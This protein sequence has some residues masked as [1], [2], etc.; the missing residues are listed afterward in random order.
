MH[1]NSGFAGGCAASGLASLLSSAGHYT[2]GVGDG[3]VRVKRQDDKDLSI[4][5]RTRAFRK[6]KSRS[7]DSSLKWRGITQT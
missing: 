3:W 2:L 7:R 6:A 1:C 5:N 4:K